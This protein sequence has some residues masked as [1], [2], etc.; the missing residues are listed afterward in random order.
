MLEAFKNYHFSI[1]QD[2]V[3][4]SYDTHWEL[5]CTL[6]NLQRADLQN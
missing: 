6:E 2:L 3:F 5:Y 4:G 1:Y